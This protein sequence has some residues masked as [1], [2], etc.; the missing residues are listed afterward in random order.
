MTC[1]RTNSFLIFSVI[2][3]FLLCTG[4]L[5]SKNVRELT[6]SKKPMPAQEIKPIKI[7][8]KNVIMNVNEMGGGIKI[9]KRWDMPEVLK[10]ISGI[11]YMDAKHFA[12][13]QDEIGIIYIYNTETRKIEDRKSTRLNS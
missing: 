12:C 6:F 8:K 3:H 10:E 4:F 2:I 9:L 7:T 11:A 13:I 1:L 5:L